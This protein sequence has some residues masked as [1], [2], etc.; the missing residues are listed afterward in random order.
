MLFYNIQNKIFMEIYK[1]K[2][3]IVFILIMINIPHN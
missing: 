2:K 3:L 1:A